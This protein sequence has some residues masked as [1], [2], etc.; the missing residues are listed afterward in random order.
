LEFRLT[1]FLNLRG[2]HELGRY[3]LIEDLPQCGAKLRFGRLGIAVGRERE[4]GVGHS[5]L[6]QRIQ[7]KSGGERLACRHQRVQLAPLAVQHVGKNLERG[8]IRAVQTG[9]PH[10]E[11]AGPLALFVGTVNGSVAAM[12]GKLIAGWVASGL[13]DQAEQGHTPWRVSPAGRDRRPATRMALF[14]AYHLS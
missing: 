1:L 6:G 10:G 12:G 5:D 13:R 4:R 14:S 11:Y 3:A 8:K 9:H 2:L 7:R